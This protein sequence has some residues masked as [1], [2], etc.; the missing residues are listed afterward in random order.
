MR[1]VC[2]LSDVG[3]YD[4]SL[5]EEV[6][7]EASCMWTDDGVF[8]DQFIRTSLCNTRFTVEVRLLSQG[9]TMQHQGCIS[10][11]LAARGLTIFQNEDE[12]GPGF[13]TQTLAKI[14]KGLT[15][16]INCS[17]LNLTPRGTYAKPLFPWTI[18]FPCPT[19]DS[20]A[21][22]AGPSRP[23]TSTCVRTFMQLYSV[24][25]L[26]LDLYVLYRSFRT[27]PPLPN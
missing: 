23:V 9:I 26:F 10:Q 22:I 8:E 4:L 12:S 14:R 3:G 11:K 18:N 1:T 6:R 24:R 17:E 25:T 20:G 27:S 7:R 16:F 19:L 5:K 15:A 13:S 21:R 2:R